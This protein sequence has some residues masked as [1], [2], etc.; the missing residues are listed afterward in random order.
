[1][2]LNTLA[3]ASQ[4]F[5]RLSGNS[6]GC[7]FHVWVASRDCFYRWINGRLLSGH[8]RDGAVLLGRSQN[9]EW[10]WPA[11]NFLPS[12]PAVPAF[13]R[14]KGT[15]FCFQ[16]CSSRFM[17]DTRCRN[18]PGFFVILGGW[19][20]WGHLMTS[21]VIQHWTVGRGFPEPGR[22]HQKQSITLTHIPLL[23]TLP[24]P[25][26][27]SFKQKLLQILLEL[28]A[29]WKV[30]PNIKLKSFETYLFLDWRKNVPFIRDLQNPADIFFLS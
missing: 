15:R 1:M 28:L 7:V 6:F 11:L 24:R 8:S 16:F 22:G 23:G 14:T 27:S 19:S 5:L 17:K 18:I 9:S 26:F 10:T 25:N 20:V 13:S 12:D 30:Y 4:T 2:P 21:N 3:E 29:V